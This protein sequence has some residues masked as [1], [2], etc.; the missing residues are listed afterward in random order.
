MVYL[1]GRMGRL[2]FSIISLGRLL[3]ESVTISY[4]IFLYLQD[5][6][7]IQKIEEYKYLKLVFL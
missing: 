3:E 6:K 4:A 5:V 2:Y 1:K 7:P